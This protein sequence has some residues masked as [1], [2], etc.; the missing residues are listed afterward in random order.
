MPIADSTEHGR[1][2]HRHRPACFRGYR[3]IRP[4]R[5]R[6]AGIRP[7]ARGSVRPTQCVSVSRG[8]AAGIGRSAQPSS[9]RSLP[10]PA[11]CSTPWG[12]RPVLLRSGSSPGNRSTLSAAWFVTVTAPVVCESAEST[13]TYAL[14]PSMNAWSPFRIIRDSGSVKFVGA[15]GPAPN[16]ETTARPGMAIDQDLDHHPRVIRRPALGPVAVP[17]DRE[18]PLARRLVPRVHGMLG[19][20]PVGELRRRQER[21]VERLPL[22]EAACRA[23]TRRIRGRSVVMPV[24]SCSSC[25]IPHKAF[26][27][28]SICWTASAPEWLPRWS[29][30]TWRLLMSR[31]MPSARQ[32]RALRSRTSSRRIS[33]SD[34]VTFSPRKVWR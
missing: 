31:Q 17:A 5:G 26:Y 15:F 34:D 1:R 9:L 12:V 14:Y 11:S 24:T 3:R 29:W 27:S 4:L 10:Y 16:G 30:Q 33:T 21:L 20:Q 19:R 13:A 8:I 23:H 2:R 32:I 28:P 6:C 25:F 22:A 18:I 7:E